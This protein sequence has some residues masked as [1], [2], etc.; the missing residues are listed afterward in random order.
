[1]RKITSK[2]KQDKK[3]R[4]NQ[5]IVGGILIFIMLF[6]T[7]G[8]SFMGKE[9]ENAKKINYNGFEFIEQN[10]LWFTNIGDLDFVF[11]YNPKQTEAV[12]SE[13]KYL[14]NYY[15]KPLYLYSEDNEAEIEIYKNLN[16]VAQ[17][18]RYACLDEEEY[19]LNNKT[20]INEM[21]CDEKWATKTCEDN[22]II[23]IKNNDSNIIQKEN[24]VDCEVNG[25]N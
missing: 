18:I 19:F 12:D 11:K 10:G 14:N 5:F 1:M 24:S 16:Q 17:R 25:E 8:Y 9:D 13:L 21:D 2:Y 22:F 6:S 7:L 4:T 15:D 20:L 23:I 3:R